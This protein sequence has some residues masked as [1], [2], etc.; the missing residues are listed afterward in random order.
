MGKS[1]KSF[2]ARL[3]RDGTRLNWTIIHIPF[4]VAK[5][6]GSRG[7]VKV[8][9]EINGYR[10]R[11]SIFPTGKRGHYLLVNKR[12]QSVANATLGTVAKFVLEPDTEERVAQIP[13]GLRKILAEHRGVAR[14]YGGLTYSTRKDIADWITEVK[15]TE[16]RQRRTEQIAER[17]F[18]VMEAEQELP[19]VLRL[20]FARD[21]AAY[22]GWQRMTA[23]Q[24]RGH[25]FGIFYY[26]NPGAQG[27]RIEKMLEE[28]RKKS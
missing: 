20:V 10:F 22:K 9:G 15:G 24:R 4:N 18:S 11:T 2:R 6:W 1:A 25:L 12:M 27:R 21:P 17:L 8:R 19:P 3:V 28:A 16:A 26:R 13:S 14:W 23:A 7:L 5:T